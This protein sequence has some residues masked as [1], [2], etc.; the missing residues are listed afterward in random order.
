MVESCKGVILIGGPQKGT[1]FRPLSMDLPKPLF[2]VAGVPMI[3]HHISACAKLP[4]LKEVLLIGCFEESDIAGFVKQCQ[5]EFDISIRYLREYTSLDTGGGLYH[6]RDHILAG[7]PDYFFVLHADICSTFPLNDIVKF[8][9]SHK[10]D[11]TIMG[12]H[13]DNIPPSYYGQ[14]VENPQTSEVLHY[15]EKPETTVSNI[16]NCGVYLFSPSIFDDIAKVF[17]K[18]HEKDDDEYDSTD[19]K[20]MISLEKDVLAPLSSSG[21]FSLYKTT[22]PW[23]QIK[24]A[25]SALH[26]NSVYLAESDL[27]APKRKSHIIATSPT[28]HPFH[29]VGNVIIHETATVDVT[30]KIGPNVSVGPGVRVEAGC[31]IKNSIILDGA[32]LKR[33]CC[34]SNSII[35]WKST[36]GEWSRV[37][38]TIQ[39]PGVGNRFVDGKKNPG[40]TILGEDVS[41]KGE[42]HVRNC[43][44]LPHKSISSSCYN[45]ILL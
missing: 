17:I 3:H 21:K 34:I 44:V 43:V 26:A 4:E 33:H 22:D 45:S 32:V 10:K 12:K 13:L 20:D 31:R 8:H 28:G 24:T 29:I 30:A 37:E 15:A 1:R 23:R 35:G 11:H 14:I 6:F 9:K 18:K 40:V 38:G 16:I 7:S 41:I 5:K 2:P 27:K 39:E 19:M 42:L 36:V 25:G